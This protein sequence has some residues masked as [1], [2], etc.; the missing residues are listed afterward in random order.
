MAPK[1]L[2]RTDDYEGPSRRDAQPQGWH[3]K[4]E[5]NLSM[6]AAMVGLALAGFWGFADLKKDVELLKANSAVLHDRD[7][8]QESN[9]K[10]AMSQLREQYRA[11]NDKLDR[12]IERER[13]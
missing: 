10:E 4:K 2:I 6:I 7:T 9:L 5:V 11:L 1:N 8:K 12:L 13:K 3:L